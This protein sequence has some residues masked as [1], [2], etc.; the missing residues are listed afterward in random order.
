V[1]MSEDSIDMRAG[2]LLALDTH[3]LHRFS[4]GFRALQL[5]H[6]A[7]LKVQKAPRRMTFHPRGTSFVLLLRPSEMPG[8]HS[9]I[10][11]VWCYHSL[12]AFE[13]MLVAF[14]TL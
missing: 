11:F 1:E 2:A 10:F 9:V 14:A 13:L 4:R 6:R 7:P 12:P 3:S 5:M 8:W